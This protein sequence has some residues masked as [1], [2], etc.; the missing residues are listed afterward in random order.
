MSRAEFKPT[1]I[2][3]CVLAI[4]EF[5]ANKKTLLVKVGFIKHPLQKEVITPFRKDGIYFYSFFVF[6][7]SLFF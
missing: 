4:N 7:V 3:Y 6:H 1:Y 5:K 2:N